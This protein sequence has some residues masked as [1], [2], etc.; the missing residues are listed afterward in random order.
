MR[1]FFCDRTK[2]QATIATHPDSNKPLR[3][4][5]SERGS[6]LENFNQHNLQ[7]AKSFNGTQLGS[8]SWEGDEDSNFSVFRVRRFQWMARTSSLNCLSPVEI[9]TKPLIHWIGLP[10]FHWKPLCGK[11]QMGALKWGLEPL[12][13]Q[14]VHN[15]LQLCTVVAL[16]EPFLR[17]TI[18]DNCGQVP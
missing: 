6:T 7:E 11:A 16:L 3:I 17:G 14:F 18:V 4:A 8:D 1:V 15:R 5:N 10:P 9:L 13:L 12:S 2:K